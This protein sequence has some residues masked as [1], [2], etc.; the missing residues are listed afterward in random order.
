[1]K[2]SLILTIIASIFL[3]TSFTSCQE[4]IYEAIME[5]VVPEEPTVSGNISSITRYTASGIEF[6]VLAAD[7]GIRYK[8]K[9]INS[10]GEWESYDTPFSLHNFDFDS[11]NHNG[12]QIIKVLADS[13]TLYLL[14]AEYEHTS[15]EGLT[16]PDNI[17][18]WGKKITANGITWD[19]GGDWKLIIEDGSTLFPI[20][21]SESTGFYESHFNVFQ[22]NSP[23]KE[24]R[25]V[26]ICTHNSEDTKFTY[27]ALNGTEKPVS[28]TISDIIDPISAEDKADEDYHPYAQSAVY[29]NGGLKFFNSSA[30]STNETY[31]TEATYYYFTN[32]DSDLY[33]GNSAG[34]YDSGFSGSYRISN[35]A[36][37]KDSLIIGYG[38]M[39]T[40]G[41]GGL[42][43]VLLSDS[44]IPMIYN[45]AGEELD[46]DFSTNAQFQI[47]NAYIVLALVN[48]TPEKDELDSSLYASITFSGTGANFENVG[49]WSYYPEREN[50][51]RE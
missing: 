44:G 15:T 21:E 12:E 19:E 25:A 35:L 32:S 8:Q 47:T 4:A 10:H 42:D 28:I 26:F 31:T 38:T 27:Y 37:C 29:F 33:Y 41:S 34:Y 13:T 48:A 18:L 3:I 39:S 9:D 45:A 23:K 2:K 51:N 7:G 43:R 1:M 16:Y 30:S 24:H 22:T 20:E 11:S 36:P 50:W 6:L 17:K 46:R 14:T 40:G 5:D 49:L